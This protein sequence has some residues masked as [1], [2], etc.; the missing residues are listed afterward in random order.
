MLKKA[1]MF[2]LDARITIIIFVTLTGVGF[3]SYYST[4]IKAGATQYITDMKSIIQAQKIFKVDT[5]KSISSYSNTYF[6]NISELVQLTIDNSKPYTKKYNGPYIDYNLG[7]TANFIEHPSLGIKAAIV[8]RPI[9]ETAWNAQAHPDSQKCST[10]TCFTWVVFYNI[11]KATAESIDRKV[12]GAVTASTGAIR[13][14]A[15]GSNFDV[16]MSMQL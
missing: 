1:A 6:Y 9:D 2:G 3:A 5:G 10:S 15:N 4:F 11:D 12:D 13:L 7:A 14:I 8:S 16:F